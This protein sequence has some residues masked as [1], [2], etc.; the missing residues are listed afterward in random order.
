MNT[1]YADAPSGW[2]HPAELLADEVTG[3][4]TRNISGNRVQRTVKILPQLS[5]EIDALS[6]NTE[7]NRNEMINRL[8]ELG[9]FALREKLTADE[10]TKALSLPTDQSKELRKESEV[11]E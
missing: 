4:A 11:D 10:R 2:I 8:L 7:I 5:Y 9:L 1:P 3:R 6:I